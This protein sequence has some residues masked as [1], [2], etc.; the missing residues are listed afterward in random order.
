MVVGHELMGTSRRNKA[1]TLTGP[2]HPVASN[3][4]SVQYPKFQLIFICVNDT[5]IIEFTHNSV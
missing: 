4:D 5:T 2:H 3:A 1:R